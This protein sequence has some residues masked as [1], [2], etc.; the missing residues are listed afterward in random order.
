MPLPVLAKVTSMS[1]LCLWNEE[2][3]LAHVS[4]FHLLLIHRLYKVLCKSSKKAWII[5]AQL[6][7]TCPGKPLQKSVRVTDQRLRWSLAA[8]RNSR[9]SWRNIAR[10]WRSEWPNS[11]DSRLIKLFPPQ[12]ICR[13]LLLWYWDRTHF[14]TS[15][16]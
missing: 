5:S 13:G 2:N 8:G 14:G 3:C 7:K 9:H 12:L 6:W 16:N 11:S 1:C 4:G 10:N 15:R